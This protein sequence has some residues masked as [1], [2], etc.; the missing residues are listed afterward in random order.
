VK[1]P[2]LNHQSTP[3]LG[4]SHFGNHCS[5]VQ[6]DLNNRCCVE[7]RTLHSALI[8][9]YFQEKPTDIFE[10]QTKPTNQTNQPTNQINQPNQSTKPNQTVSQQLLQALGINIPAYLN[11]LLFCLSRLPNIC[12]GG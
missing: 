6:F 5:I 8:S 7:Q 11:L 12:P 9:T 4:V 1:L 2:P 3:L 10:K